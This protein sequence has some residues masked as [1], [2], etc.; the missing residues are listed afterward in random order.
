MV[1]MAFVK[2]NIFSQVKKKL[3]INI[4]QIS[5]TVFVNEQIIIIFL[6]I[7][8]LLIYTFFFILFHLYNFIL[9]GD[10]H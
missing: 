3:E 4:F 5:L 8:F 9:T 10:G 6:F 7:L 1:S 2:G